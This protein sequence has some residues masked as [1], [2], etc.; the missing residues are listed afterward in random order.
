MTEFAKEI[1]RLL[2]KEKKS[3]EEIFKYY[4]DPFD[5]LEEDKEYDEMRNPKLRDQDRY[6]GVVK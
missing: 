4:T 6:G 2:E 3:D 1:A 5:V